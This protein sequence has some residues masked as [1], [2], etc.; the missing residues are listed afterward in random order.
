MNSSY[1]CIH[2]TLTLKITW[3]NV[4]FEWLDSFMNRSYVPYQ[5]FSSREGHSNLSP[6]SSSPSQINLCKSEV[7]TL[8]LNILEFSKFFMVEIEFGT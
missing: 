8:S 2:I 1:V 3:A 4:T 7:G 5:F 6:N